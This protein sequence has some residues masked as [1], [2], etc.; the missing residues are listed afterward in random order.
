MLTSNESYVEQNVLPVE[1]EPYPYPMLML[2]SLRLEGGTLLHEGT[3]HEPHTLAEGESLR[4]VGVTL[5][6]A[7]PCLDHG[8]DEGAHCDEEHAQT[9]PHLRCNCFTFDCLNAVD[10]YS[11]VLVIQLFRN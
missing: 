7:H 8:P 10:K 11:S 6:E 2:T 1:H 3:V 4:E 5:A 9:H